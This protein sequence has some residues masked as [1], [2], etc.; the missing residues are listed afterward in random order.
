MENFLSTKEITLLRRLG[1]QVSEIAQDPK[2]KEKEKLWK[3][4]NTLHKTRPLILCTI[5]EA[6][7]DE[8]IPPSNLEIQDP[9]FRYYERYLKKQIYRSMNLR[10]DEIIDNKIYVPYILHRKDWIEGRIRPYDARPDHSAKFTPCIL[11]T[12]DLKKLQFPDFEYDEAETRRQFEYVQE[13][14][15]DSMEV[16][17]GEPFYAS[18]ESEILGWGHSLIDLWCE[19]RG[20]GTVFYDLYDEPEFTK[21]AMAFLQEGTL[22]YLR[23]YEKTGLLKLNNNGFIKLTNTP[24]GSNA[25]GCTDELPSKEFDGTNVT[26]RD[27]WGYSMAQEF[28]LISP[29]MLEEFVLKFQAPIAD[30]FGL[31]A[32][33]CCENNDAKWD[34]LQKYIPRIRE[35]SVPFASSLET[36]VDKLG[37]RF[38]LCWKPNVVDLIGH[39]DTV[40]LRTQM[41][42]EMETAKKCHL[43]YALRDAQTLF[44]DIKRAAAWTEM[45]MEMAREYGE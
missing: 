8:M 7:W 5:A 36:A 23:Q 44:G 10:D 35:M 3:K 1:K 19:L 34:V 6:G 45:A 37:D 9:F 2:W 24:L 20:L 39:D 40:R 43:V 41:R 14:F 42:K 27:L 31:N 22:R 18:T 11:E 38:V 16:V 4:K 33:G 29:D 32:Y 30:M 15:G 25:L 12:N 17:L 21:E 26:F 28:T 13:V